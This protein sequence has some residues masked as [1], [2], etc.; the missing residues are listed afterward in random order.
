MTRTRIA[1]TPHDILGVS[2]TATLEEIRQ[3]YR[4]GALKYHPDNF[5]QDP[6]KAEEKFRELA[7]AYTPAMR[8]HLP[9]Y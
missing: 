9:E 5:R 8:A 4:K 7:R 1:I 6:A 3:A 2:H